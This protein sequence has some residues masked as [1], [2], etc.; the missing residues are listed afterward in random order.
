[1]EPGDSK[2]NVFN[3]SITIGTYS[4][5]YL[6][7][8]I[9]DNTMGTMKRVINPNIANSKSRYYVRQNKVL[10]KLSDYV[11][12]N[13]GF[14]EGVFPDVRQV[15]RVTPLAQCRIST[16]KELPNISL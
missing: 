8:Q 14:E 9:V 16:K 5:C 2:D 3:L 1:M 15:D 10:T 12:D 11:L 6:T 7:L 13:C 4:S